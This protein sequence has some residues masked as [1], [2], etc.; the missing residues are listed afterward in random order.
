IL[1]L[2][3]KV[4]QS[5]LRR[6]DA[7]ARYGGDEFVLLLPHADGGEA[8]RVVQRIREEFEA[9]SAPILNRVTGVSMSVGISSSRSQ[10]PAHAE[11]LVS[12][13]DVALYQAKA[14]GRGR[15][16]VSGEAATWAVGA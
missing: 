10:R 14:S 3:G 12:A 8:A 16:V 9:A 5:N 2:A 11:Q 4:I 1:V 7:A 15:T 13:A 6:M